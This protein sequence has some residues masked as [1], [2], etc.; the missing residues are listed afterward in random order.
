[1]SAGAL[2]VTSPRMRISGSTTTNRGRDAHGTE[3]V[4]TRD[5]RRSFSRRSRTASG[6]TIDEDDRHLERVRDAVRRVLRLLGGA[7]E[8]AIVPRELDLDLGVARA[9]D[10]LLEEA[11]EAPAAHFLERAHEVARLDDAACVAVQVASHALP[12]ERVAELGAEHVEHEAALLVE[13]PI[14]DVDRRLV[15]LADDRPAV[16]A[17]SP[18]RG[19]CRGRPRTP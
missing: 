12:E 8:D 16:A 18:R 7:A 6:S 2:T 17:A 14:E 15:V 11:S 10:Q 5:V 1:M 13:V 9:I 19:S 3:N 4:S